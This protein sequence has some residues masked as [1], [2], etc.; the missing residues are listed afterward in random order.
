MPDSTPK[1]RRVHLIGHGHIDPV[2]LWRWQE[3]YAEAWA[4][5]RSALDRM[6][7]TR[8]CIFTASSAAL[9]QWIQESDPAMFREI[10]KR[11]TQ[12]RWE[13][14]GG[15]WVEPDCNI[16]SGES[17]VRHGLY[18][19]RYF[20]KNLG[21]RCSVGF[22]PDSFGHPG[23]LPKL[24][25]GCGLEG[26]VFM[27]PMH[28]ENPDIPELAFQWKGDDG[29]VLPALR[30]HRSYNAADPE[31]LETAIRETLATAESTGLE[32]DVCVFYGIGNH[33]GGPTRALLSMIETWKRDRKMPALRYS[34]VAGYLDVVR[35]RR[36]PS[37]N[38]E[39]HMHAP[40]CFSAVS[41]LKAA[42]R[43]AEQ[44]LVGAEMWSAA[45][46]TVTR[47]RPDTA[48]FEEAWKHVLF[49]QFHDILA[50]TSLKVACSDAIRQFGIAIH[51]AAVESNAAKQQISR[52]IDTRGE[53]QPLV[54]FNNLPFG[55]D[56]VM[57]TEDTGFLEAED[58]RTIAGIV[59]AAGN[60]VPSQPIQPHSVCGRQ[61]F[62]VKTGIPSLGYMLLRTTRV[63]KSASKRLLGPAAVR[64]AERRLANEHLRLGLDR[65]G[66][67]TLYDRRARRNV[68]APAGGLPI[69]IA[70]TSD[71]WSHGIRA[72]RKQ[73]GRFR[74]RRARILET[75]PVRGCLE[76]VYTWKRSTLTLHY[77]LG[78]GE[79]FVVVRGTVDWRQQWQM[80]KLAFP[81]PFES[82]I[83]TAES[84][85][86]TVERVTNGH[87]LPI[88]R[89]AD[90]SDGR[91]GF[92]VVTDGKYS[93]SC[94]PGDLRLTILRSPPYA[95]HIPFT[96]K[97]TASLS[98]TDQGLQHFTLALIPHAGDWR[99]AGVLEISGRINRPPDTLRETF[100]RGTLPS[101]AA[102]ATCRGR[103]VAIETLK[104]AE[105]GRGLI[106]RA[107]E[108]FGRRR[109]AT[110]AL[111]AARRTWS[112]TFRP[113][114]VK[115]FRIPVSRR[116][117]VEEVNM[118]EDAN[119]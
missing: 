22:C 110:F 84:A 101:T 78:T 23:T 44:A 6:K 12:G 14:V 71:T 117:P 52:R 80:L 11:V 113:H 63:A 49:N 99:E 104:G 85:Y 7:E 56:G 1:R 76:V 89:W 25:K 60:P 103:G 24:L 4:T 107:V 27:R 62:V 96:I 37:W 111:P 90:I 73:A 114:E 92:A 30:I 48:A 2:W 87:E 21:R 112:A 69:V 118:L 13:I 82:R 91:R 100:H 72:F 34:S 77:Q 108:W 68:F 17:L 70:D 3:G 97:D 115:T 39:M 54:A 106:L 46:S 67:I 93:C 5:F 74:F 45:A 36:L 119:R 59:D 32:D 26:Y 66:G 65:R 8:G 31:E 43:R 116:S 15:W 38:G 95:Y 19:Q 83:W 20:M 81:V 102:C 61:R 41:A 98:Y 47:R 28:G 58:S 86:G 10:R 109:K 75:G 29:T 18:G 64:T 88:H 57:E 16:P 94:E 50:G 35:S 42:N 9:Y 51:G 40:G 53:A 105:D 79:P 55:F 33:G